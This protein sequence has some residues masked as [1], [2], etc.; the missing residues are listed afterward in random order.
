[1]RLVEVFYIFRGPCLIQLPNIR[2]SYL[3][4]IDDMFVIMQSLDNLGPNERKANNIPQNIGQTMKHAGHN[5]VKTF[6][7]SQFDILCASNDF[8]LYI[9]TTFCGDHLKQLKFMN[10]F[11]KP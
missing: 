3:V 10:L 6:L 11:C 9:L 1:M 8:K 4:G 2:R 7:K 5:G